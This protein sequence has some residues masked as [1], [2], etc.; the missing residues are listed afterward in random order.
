VVEVT[1]TP[2]GFD[3]AWDPSR[4]GES[5]LIETGEWCEWPAW[6]ATS[7][8]PQHQLQEPSYWSCP[9][10]LRP[11]WQ[12]Q[13]DRDRRPFRSGK[14]QVSQSGLSRTVPRPPG[15]T[16][17]DFLRGVCQFGDMCKF[18]HTPHTDSSAVS[19]NRSRCMYGHG[20]VTWHARPFTYGQVC[21]PAKP[22]TSNGNRI[23]CTFLEHGSC[24]QGDS[25]RFLHVR[26]NTQ[27]TRC[28]L[29]DR[30]RHSHGAQLE[31]AAFVPRGTSRLVHTVLSTLLGWWS[32]DDGAS[33]LEVR[34]G[35]STFGGRTQLICQSWA[36]GKVSSC[37]ETVCYEQGD[38][39]LG[40]GQ[41]GKT[42]LCRFLDTFTQKTASWIRVDD[43]TDVRK[44][45]K[46]QPPWRD[47]SKRVG[48][49]QRTWCHDTITDAFTDV[50]QHPDTSTLDELAALDD[51]MAQEL[52]ML[53]IQDEELEGEMQALEALIQN[54][55]DDEEVEQRLQI[56]A[57]DE[58]ERNVGDSMISNTDAPVSWTM[59]Q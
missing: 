14:R 24:P 17:C 30:C 42:R 58:S 47:G 51:D 22:E 59:F 5:Y 32:A 53:S 12:Q 41:S 43:H 15:A 45:V 2:L 55:P 54:L 50:D 16:C 44:W 21:P 23:C 36:N 49:T 28:S 37:M 13:G 52:R 4:F 19:C 3:G 40:D 9:S 18:E 31:H 10:E 33:F 48:H 46:T 56:E 29:G 11:A 8:G 7:G 27:Q 57:Q 26:S 34:S 35:D 20:R 25:C 1:S 6:Y 39:I 38:V